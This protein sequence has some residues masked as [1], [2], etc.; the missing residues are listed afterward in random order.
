MWASALSP[1]LTRSP[2]LPLISQCS[3]HAGD[4]SSIGRPLNET[5][6]TG[7]V[8]ISPSFI[9]ETRVSSRVCSHINRYRLRF[10]A[11]FES[12]P[13]IRN[14]MEW[15]RREKR[16]KRERKNT[17]VKEKSLKLER[18]R[19]KMKQKLFVQK[20]CEI[21]FPIVRR[22]EKERYLL[23]TSARRLKFIAPLSFSPFG[24]IQGDTKLSLS[25]TAFVRLFLR[26]QQRHVW[27]STEIS[28]QFSFTRSYLRTFPE[29]FLKVL[30][31]ERTLLLNIF[32]LHNISFTELSYH[33]KYNF[34]HIFDKSYSCIFFILIPILFLVT[35]RHEEEVHS[36]YCKAEVASRVP[37]L[38]F[39]LS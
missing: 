21:V 29:S 1:F 20:V 30:I 38:H 19:N 18:Y 4:F 31:S 12:W 6:I 26:W 33:W 5:A 13:S 28:S 22:L 24:P 11:I 23:A 37:L 7:D 10:S 9:R 27:Y 3:Y 32:S 39:V 36:W 35:L 8:G 34:A 14:R 15:S 25:A 16:K 17:S 2:F